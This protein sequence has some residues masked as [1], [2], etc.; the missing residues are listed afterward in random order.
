MFGSPIVYPLS[1]LHELQINDPQT[2]AAISKKWEMSSELIRTSERAY[3]NLNTLLSWPEEPKIGDVVRWLPQTIAPLKA[4]IVSELADIATGTKQPDAQRLMRLTR[5]SDLVFASANDEWDGNH[6]ASAELSA[7]I[8]C[9]K[10]VALWSEHPETFAV[11]SHIVESVTSVTPEDRYHYEGLTHFFTHQLIHDRVITQHDID[12]GKLRVIGNIKPVSRALKSDLDDPQFEAYVRSIADAMKIPDQKDTYYLLDAIFRNANSENAQLITQLFT[13]LNER[14]FM[15]YDQRRCRIHTADSRTFDKVV[16]TFHED[17]RMLNAGLFVGQLIS[18]R[19]R[20]IK[21]NHTDYIRQSTY[22]GHGGLERKKTP[23]DSEQNPSRA[24]LKR[25][26]QMTLG[27]LVYTAYHNH[28]PVFERSFGKKPVFLMNVEFQVT[29]G[30]G[31]ME[32]MNRMAALAYDAQGDYEKAGL[33]MDYV[34]TVGQR[35]Q[36]ESEQI[37]E[38][39]RETGFEKAIK[40]DSSFSLALLKTLAGMQ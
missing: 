29:L 13:Q 35:A 39:G 15:G 23:I 16:R 3:E 4:F 24:V 30:T 21:A 33:T 8:G 20:S 19:P 37:E 1:I 36:E 17:L 2:A 25:L 14:R 11:M 22:D 9:L 6:S 7:M 32:Q 31:A 18:S 27:Q 26:K 28:S 10:D 34:A 40:A 38:D 5:M 12:T